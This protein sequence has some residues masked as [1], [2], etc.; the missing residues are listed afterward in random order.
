MGNN[1]YRSLWKYWFVIPLCC[2][3]FG[4]INYWPYKSI[5]CINAVKF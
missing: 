1:E 5:E 4:L 3:F 2:V